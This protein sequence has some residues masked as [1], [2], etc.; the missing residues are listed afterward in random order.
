VLYGAQVQQLLGRLIRGLIFG[1]QI[2][3]GAT[4]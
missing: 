1:R 4:G 3:D 2:E